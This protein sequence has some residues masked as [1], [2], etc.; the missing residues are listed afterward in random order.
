MRKP[1]WLKRRKTHFFLTPISL[2]R[3]AAL[4]K[5][6]GMRRHVVIDALIRSFPEEDA[7]SRVHRILASDAEALNA[8]RRFS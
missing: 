6:T 3:I 5:A 7:E 1:D 4:E 2:E 8:W